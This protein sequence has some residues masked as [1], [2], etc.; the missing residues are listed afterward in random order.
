[1]ARPDETASTEELRRHLR[2][3]LPSHMV[4][5]MLA[6][7]AELPLTPHGKLDRRADA[8]L[9][10][11]LPVPDIGSEPPANPTEQAIAELW[12]KALGCERVARHDN[13]FDLGGHSLLL[14]QVHDA[15]V[16]RLG[17]SLSIIDLFRLP[18]LSLVAQA[19]AA[20]QRGTSASTTRTWNGSAG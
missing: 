20:D 5:A 15:M 19:V 13:F 11:M 8:A 10:A 17:T 9:P 2:A 18:T 4:P 3:H 14:V 6:W 16:E 12:C 7:V 1:M